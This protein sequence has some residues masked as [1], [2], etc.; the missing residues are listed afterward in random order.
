MARECFVDGVIIPDLPFEEAGAFNKLARRYNL[1]LI[2][3]IAPTTSVS[4]I[5]SIASK[6]RGFIY[7]V[8]L[9]GTTGARKDLPA[10]IAKN[11]RAIKKIT[12][13]PVCVGFG[14][15]NAA[16]VKE[17]NKIAD[18]AIVGSAI[19]RKIKE[20]IGKKDLVK[21]VGSFVRGL[22]V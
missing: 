10:D 11:I 20:N 19:V 2:S 4:R 18:G 12:T 9:I 13:K 3:F 5:K 7:Y 8:S 17:I 16:Q 6:T 1:D 14:I 22:H 15:S 21:K